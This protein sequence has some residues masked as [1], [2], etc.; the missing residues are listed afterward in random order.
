MAPTAST[1]KDETLTPACGSSV[2]VRP[3]TDAELD[4]GSRSCKRHSPGALRRSP[5]R[6][7]RRHVDRRGPLA[8]T[9]ATLSLEGVDGHVGPAATQERL[10]RDVGE[11]RARRRVVDINVGVVAF[12]QPGHE[13][14]THALV[15]ATL[16]AADEASPRASRELRSSRVDAERESPTARR[17]AWR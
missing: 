6:L 15:G 16:D 8:V 17:P 5:E 10:Y 9:T 14:K 11:P 1:S 13:R 2:R 7:R 4:A 3:F 12:G